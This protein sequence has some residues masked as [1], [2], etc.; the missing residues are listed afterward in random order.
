[1]RTLNRNKRSFWFCLLD[2]K[3]PIIDEYGNETGE[4]ILRYGTPTKMS[5][6]VSP[7]TGYSQTEQ[8]G[9]LDN[10]DKVIVTDWM[11][12]PIDENSVLFIDKGVEYADAI[13][14]E[15]TPSD[16]VL[17]DDEAVPVTVEVPVYDYTVRRVAKSLNSI[18]IAVSKRN[19]S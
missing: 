15:Y 14:I 2:E 7:A 5:A 18:S 16:T 17:G 13:T 4:Y 1:M 8:F 6:N 12:C 3:I 9:N 19:V 11:D 10:Y